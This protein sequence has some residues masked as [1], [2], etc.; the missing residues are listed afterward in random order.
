[1][2]QIPVGFVREGV[3]LVIGQ[4][5][6]IDESVLKQEL[7][8]LMAAGFGYVGDWLYIDN[9]A[10][11]LLP[12]DKKTEEAGTL[13]DRIGSTAKGIGVARAGRIM[14]TQPVVRD[15]PQ[16]SGLG[17]GGVGHHTSGII[18]ENLAAGRTVIV[19]GT[20]GFELSLHGWLYPYATSQDC[21]ALDVLAQAGIPPWDDSVN[22]FEVWVV[23]RTYPI[24]VAGKSG[25]MRDE[26]TWEMLK[27]RSNGYIK[28]EKTT[29]TQ[30][31]RRVGE[32]DPNLAERAVNANGGKHSW[33]LKTALMM[34]DY[35]NPKFAGIT[36]KEKDAGLLQDLRL[37]VEPLERPIGRPFDLLGTGPQS[38]VDRRVGLNG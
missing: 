31:V 34:T 28:P 20:Q 24:R 30:R 33:S 25:P 2:R 7:N 10:T 37:A 15:F 5:S 22:A 11:V 14:R 38:I 36:E 23:F 32:W 26:I 8:D 35:L 19:E 27:Y 16:I 6:V 18:R 9:M 12:L 4:G 17:Q 3:D 21:T 29:V 13:N 1:M